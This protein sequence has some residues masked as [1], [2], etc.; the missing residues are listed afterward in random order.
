MLKLFP[1][2]KILKWIDLPVANPRRV[3]TNFADPGRIK[4]AA[5]DAGYDMVG[6]TNPSKMPFK[7]YTPGAMHI[8]SENEYTYREQ[9]GKVYRKIKHANP[10]NEEGE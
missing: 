4:Q 7:K 10:P 6:S 2:K 5:L 3:P 9:D 8:W 1:F